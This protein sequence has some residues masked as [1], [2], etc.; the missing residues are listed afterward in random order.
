MNEVSFDK[1]PH[2]LVYFTNNKFSLHGGLNTRSYDG[3]GNTA[4]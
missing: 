2:S 3:K 4:F 1:S